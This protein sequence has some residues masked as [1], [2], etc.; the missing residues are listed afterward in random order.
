MAILASS[1]GDSGAEVFFERGRILASTGQFE[2]AIKMF[3][4]GLGIAPDAMEAHVEL[5]RIALRRKAV[6][7]RD[8]GLFDQMKLRRSPDPIR[9]MLNAE[10]RL[11]YRPDDRDR[12][13]EVILH[14]KAA[15][16]EDL[17]NW[18]S[19]IRDG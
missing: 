3:I 10:H 14:A 15:G 18:M 19:E 12:M 9:S 7:L 2:Y 6:A 8:M 5:R 16:L 13:S 11:A 17:V 1:S 4:G